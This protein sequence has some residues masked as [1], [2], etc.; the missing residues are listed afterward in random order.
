M[1]GRLSDR[2][3][4]ALVSTTMADPSASLVSLRS[5]PDAGKVCALPTTEEDLKP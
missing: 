1:L 5:G 3:E 2:A 4:W